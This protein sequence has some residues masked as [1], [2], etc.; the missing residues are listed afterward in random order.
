MQLRTLGCLYPSN[1][2]RGRSSVVLRQQTPGCSSQ[3]EKGSLQLFAQYSPITLAPIPS[4]FLLDDND[5]V[6]TRRKQSRS[7]TLPNIRGEESEA[8]SIQTSL[9]D[10]TKL[11]TSSSVVVT[12][13]D[14]ERHKHHFPIRD[15]KT[16]NLSEF[17]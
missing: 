12:S 9:G 7:V 1:S 13:A 3:A 14:I 6:D 5:K 4:T 2:R 16:G 10:V 8:G 17:S 11:W 15:A